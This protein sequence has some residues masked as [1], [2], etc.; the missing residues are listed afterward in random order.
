[1]NDDDDRTENHSYMSEIDESEME[2]MAA[3]KRLNFDD[4]SARLS[5]PVSIY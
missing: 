3:K 4:S 5:N 2:I 1:M